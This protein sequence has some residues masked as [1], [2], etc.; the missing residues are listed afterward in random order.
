MT[1]FSE[2]D[3][4][5]LE[6]I[7]K[8]NLINSCSGYKSANLIGTKSVDGIENVAVFSSVTHIGSSPAMLG[9]FLR[10]TTVIRN[11]YE[12]LKSTGFYTINHIHQNITEE[13][14]HTSAKYDASISEFDATQLKSEYKSEFL[15]PFVK[16]APIQLAMQ[17]VEEYNI[18]ANN[19]I[20]VIG[21]IVG[22]YIN[23]DLVEDDGFVN[24]TKAKVAAINGLDGY[25]IPETKTRYG[26][27]RPKELKASF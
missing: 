16:E 27:Q 23:G 8:I 22:L 17:F 21:K 15:A 3:I 19:T 25:V 14:H 24:L 7:Y 10:P 18:K 1:Y 6:H 5:N 11:T 4:E 20:L 12:N 26:Y 9:F 2:S 13:A